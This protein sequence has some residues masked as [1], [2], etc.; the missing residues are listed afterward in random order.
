MTWV[1]AVTCTGFICDLQSKIATPMCVHVKVQLHSWCFQRDIAVIVQILTTYSS[2][3]YQLCDFAGQLMNMISCPII[4]DI[5]MGIV[6]LK[7][8]VFIRK[9]LHNYWPQIIFRDIYIVVFVYGTIQTFNSSYTI[10]HYVS[11]NHYTDLSL[12]RW[13]HTI[14]ESYRVVICKSSVFRPKNPDFRL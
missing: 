13:A 5:N 1:S 4:F 14:G 11:Q 7:H 6:I 9:M 2:I 12:D 10:P 3:I 8:V